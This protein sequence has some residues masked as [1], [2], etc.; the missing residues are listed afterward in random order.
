MAKKVAEQLVEM[1]VEAGVKR[2]YA[3]TGDS[4]NEVND[5]VRRNGELQWVHVRHEEVGAFAAGAEAQLNGLACC[6]GSSGPGHVHLI[7]GLYDAHRSGAPVIAIASTEASFEFGTEHFQETNTIKLFDDCSCYN[8]VA[9]T[10]QQFARMFQAGIQHAISR[11]GVAVVGLPGDV[12]AAEAEESMTAS[13]VYRTN[14]ITRPSD[15]ELQALA[16]LLN[17]YDKVTLYCGLGAAE[18]HDELIKLA[19]L[20]QSPIGYTFRGKLEIQYANPYEVGMTGLLGM[21]SGYHSMHE[22]ELLVLLGTD[23]P[24]TAFMPV[25]PKIVQIDIRPERLGRRAKLDQGLCGAIKP[26]LQALIPLIRQ[27]TDDSFLKEQLDLYKQVQENMRAYVEDTGKHDAIHPEYV[28]VV[29]DK[30]A[31][32]DAIFTV[33]TGMSCVWGARYISATGK[34]VM[35]GSWNHGSMANAMPQAIG[36]ALARPGQQVVAMCGDGGLTMLLGDLST[37]VQYELPIK[38]IVF[39]NRALG[40]VKLEMEVAGLPD[41]QTDMPNTDFAAIGQA[42]GIH[43]VTV[44]E[45]G[46]V[47]QALEQA[48]AHPGPV[49]VNVL[50]DPNALAMPPKVEFDQ[51]KGFA[52]SMSKLIL[53][54]RMD[55]VL[56]TIKTNYKHMREVL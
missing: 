40:M 32:D 54:G 55:E 31:A 42:M 7:N 6:A 9:S 21:P 29:I 27:K 36:A 49:L 22:S 48:F 35:M 53:G 24:Y 20:L 15:E 45:P 23:F 12:A 2:I 50:T 34:R 18:A 13:Q 39:N 26:T 52:L 43:S 11:K 37:I 8:Q 47:Q 28:S 30:L 33:D 51:V 56:D 25:K 3:V 10:P 1:L 4:L 16:N 41:W 14:P 46:Q 17:E 5:A 19:G 44:H 38:I